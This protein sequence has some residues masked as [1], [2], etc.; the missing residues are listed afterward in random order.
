MKKKILILV[1]LCSFINYA[2]KKETFK[3]GMKFGYNKSIINGIDSFGEDTGVIEYALYAGFFANAEFNN[4]WLLETELIYSYSLD[5]NFVEI[6]LHVKY[7]ISDKFTGFIG[8]KL[9]IIMDDDG[10]S[11][12]SGSY[13]FNNFGFSLD[14]GLQYDISKR[15]F[16]ETRYSWGFTKQITDIQLDINE[17]KPNTF[18]I[19]LGYKFN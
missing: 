3:F 15:F 17:G 9:D 2:Q 11:F 16:V 6:P 14:V 18:R 5:I 19:G 4:K 1:F 7:R 10:D 8:P 13:R 12:E